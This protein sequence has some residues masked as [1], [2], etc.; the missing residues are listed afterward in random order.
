ME[1]V[2]KLDHKEQPVTDLDLL[3]EDSLQTI[4]EAET[5]DAETPDTETLIP[6]PLRLKPLRLK[7]LILKPLRLKPLMLKPL[8]LKPL[9][10]SRIKLWRNP[11]PLPKPDTTCKRLHPRKRR[12]TKK[13]RQRDGGS[14][15]L[16]ATRSS[17]TGRR[18]Q[19]SAIRSR[20]SW[21]CIP[22]SS[23][24]PKGTS[25]SVSAAGIGFWFRV[26]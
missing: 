12:S 16:L 18:D 24:R 14:C 19:N 26:G 3:G 10:H 17:K 5:P 6:K 25:C 8:M 4:A 2:D 1:E 21:T 22:V 11:S 7:P 13:S 15:A 20:K 9:M 23:S